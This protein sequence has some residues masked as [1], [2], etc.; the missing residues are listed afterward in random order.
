MQYNIIP[1]TPPPLCNELV[2]IITFCVH[3]ITIRRNMIDSCCY[4][5]YIINGVTICKKKKFDL[6]S[7][8]SN[9][10]EIE[11]TENSDEWINWIEDAISKNY[12]KYFEYNHFNNIQ[13]IGFGSFGKVYRANW[14]D[15]HNHLVLKSFSN[16]NNITIKDIVNE[17][18]YVI[19]V[20]YCI[21]LSLRGVTYLNSNSIHYL[22]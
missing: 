1:L 6:H 12:L 15:F 18:N 13:E 10:S 3:C 21:F 19:Y 2:S 20:A 9:N 7:I 5:Q 8:M 11:I 22:A 14:K 4:V 17:V 16:F